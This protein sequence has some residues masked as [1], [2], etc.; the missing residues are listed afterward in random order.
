MIQERLREWVLV[1]RMHLS[2]L[3]DAGWYSER[4]KL[5][6]GTNPYRHYLYGGWMTCDPSPRFSNERYL[7]VNQDVARRGMCPLDHYLMNGRKEGRQLF[8]GQV[9][10][11]RWRYAENSGETFPREVA[12]GTSGGGE[13]ELVSVVIP[14]YNRAGSI[15]ESCQSVLGQTYSSIELIVV[16]DCSE[17]NTEEIVRGIKDP[18]VRYIRHERNQGACAARNTGIQ[19]ARG[20]YIAFQ[21][22]DD[23]WFPEKLEKQMKALQSSDAEICFCGYI[24]KESEKV[25]VRGPSCYYRPG[26]QKQDLAT[27]FGIGTQTLL[28]KRVVLL[29]NLFDQ[30]MPRFQDLELLLRLVHRY[31]VYYCD[32]ALVLYR[33]GKDSISANGE[34]LVRACSLLLEK[35]G[36]LRKEFPLLCR[37]LAG[38]LLF[39]AKREPDPGRRKQMAELAIKYDQSWKVR[40]EAIEELSGK[41]RKEQ[42]SP[43]GKDS[44]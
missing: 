18:R 32:E 43:S 44:A 6:R 10:G 15:Y 20:T 26:I 8:R 25:Q 35:H 29:K 2:P 36:S 30:E 28:I 27:V 21:D 23:Y 16:D 37:E 17:D 5:P 33:T 7:E 14:T 12:D 24:H 13:K 39:E 1:C 34:R 31:R 11:R 41:K 40:K 38:Y 3:F 19:E 42:E 22:S 4:Q 9:H